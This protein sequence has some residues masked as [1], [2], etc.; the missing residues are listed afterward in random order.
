MHK[1]LVIKKVVQYSGAHRFLYTLSSEQAEYI[2]WE[3][4]NILKLLEHCKT[5][6]DNYE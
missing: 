1:V 6:L 2:S 3:T 5:N 4:K